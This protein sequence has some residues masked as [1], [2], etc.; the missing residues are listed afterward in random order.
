MPETVVTVPNQRIPQSYADA[1]GF[2][3]K[4]VVSGSADAQFRQRRDAEAAERRAMALY[5]VAPGVVV[6]RGERAYRPEEGVP[7]ETAEE[8][9]ALEELTRRGALISITEQELEQRWATAE[10]DRSRFRV[11]IVG[12]G[13]LSAPSGRTFG[14]G[15]GIAAEDLND[16]SGVGGERGLADFIERGLVVDTKAKGR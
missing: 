5:T 10:T 7:F 12:R 9:A 16:S 8:R 14:D 1:L 3:V 4:S 11:R 15:D 6:T 13:V 2:K